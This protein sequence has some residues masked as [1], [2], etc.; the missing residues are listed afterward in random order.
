MEA[1]EGGG[2]G[3]TGGWM[4]IIH[5]SLRTLEVGV[6]A[7]GDDAEQEKHGLITHCED[8]FQYAVLRVWI[9]ISCETH[10]HHFFPFFLPT[11]CD[12]DLE[13]AP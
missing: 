4:V 10:T 6:A 13:A 1:K 12:D 2:E 3:A 11:P 7:A 9:C 8:T 5:H